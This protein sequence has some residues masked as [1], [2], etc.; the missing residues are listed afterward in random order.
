MI[1]PEGAK[2]FPSKIVDEI[3]IRRKVIEAPTMDA[4]A[5]TLYVAIDPASHHRSSM[6]MSAIMYTKTGQIIVMGLAAVQVAK[7]E[8]LQ[9]VSAFK[10]IHSTLYA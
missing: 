1:Q 4:K 10:T 5:V 6:G 3:V 9:G 2:Y 8:I 7:C